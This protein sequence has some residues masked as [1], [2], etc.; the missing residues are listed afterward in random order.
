MDT[1]YTSFF[2]K[3]YQ[4]MQYKEDENKYIFYL[5]TTSQSA[6]C[7]V[8]GIESQRVHGYEKRTARDLP[9]F[10][11]S[12]L[13]EIDRKKFFCVDKNCS[14][15]IFIEQNGFIGS[16]SQFTQRC[17]DYMLKV[18]TYVSCEAAV[19]ILA[20]QG[21]RVCGDTLLTML[22]NAGLANKVSMPTK[23]GID[24]WAYHKGKSYGTIICDLETREVIDILEGCDSE[25]LE[26]WLKGHQNLMKLMRQTQRQPPNLSQHL[27]QWN[28]LL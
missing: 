3:E 15:D 20:Y 26:T 23:I 5:H 19:K 11:K 24:D 9:I 7:P 16:Y 27:H 25:V 8:C 22:K 28:A 2:P 1:L 21:I 10:G 17:R 14:V 6:L 18:A 12:V 13:L 4:V